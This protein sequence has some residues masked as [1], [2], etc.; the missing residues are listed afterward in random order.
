MR[1]A[2]VVTVADAGV[3]VREYHVETDSPDEALASTFLFEDL[4]SRGQPAPRSHRR[5]RLPRAIASRPRA[6]RAM[7]R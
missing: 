1:P 3:D 4:F 5:S 6:A 7:A 2:I